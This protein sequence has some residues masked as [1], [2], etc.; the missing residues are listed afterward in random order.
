VEKRAEFGISTTD[1]LLNWRTEDR[2]T[3]LASIFQESPYIIYGL[4]RSG[5]ESPS[6]LK[7][8]NVG[9]F[10]PGGIGEVA[11]RTMFAM[12]GLDPIRDFPKVT[13]IRRG[14][15]DITEGLVDA[16]SGIR[17]SSRGSSISPA[18]P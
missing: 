1:V 13:R 3:V 15:K 14:L 6:D 12:S 8:L 10:R 16:A 2:L 7:G 4:A 18:S 5:L 17:S 9:F 11:A